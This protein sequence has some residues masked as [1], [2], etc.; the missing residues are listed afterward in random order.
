MVKRRFWVCLIRVV[1]AGST[2]I[3]QIGNLRYFECGRGTVRGGRRALLSLRILVTRGGAFSY[4][5]HLNRCRLFGRRRDRFG[6]GH[7]WHGCGC[8]RQDLE[9]LAAAR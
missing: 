2:A 1:Q 5:R 3:Q 6:G 8:S 4:D 9:G 7:W